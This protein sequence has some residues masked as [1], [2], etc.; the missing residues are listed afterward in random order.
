MMK[1]SLALTAAAFLTACSTEPE[2]YVAAADPAHANKRIAAAPVLAGVQ[3]FRVTGP[4][5]WIQ[6]NQAVTPTQIGAVEGA[7]EGARRE[8]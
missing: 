2:I 5:D 7:A 3:T 8:R 6:S 4:R 1:A